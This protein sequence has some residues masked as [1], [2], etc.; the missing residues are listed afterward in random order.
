MRKRLILVFTLLA[1]AVPSAA[2]GQTPTQNAYSN[3]LGQQLNGVTPNGPSGPSGGSPTSGPTNANAPS[4]QPGAPTTARTV[5]QPTSEGG[6]PFTGL[7][8]ALAALVG[9]MLIAAGLMIRRISG[10]RS[11]PG[12]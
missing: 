9:A 2:W 3:Q 1:L 10:S 12:L 11:T 6:L 7:Q 4:T 8:I 5:A